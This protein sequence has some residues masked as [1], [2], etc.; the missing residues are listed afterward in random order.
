MKLRNTA[1]GAAVGRPPSRR[2]PGSIRGAAA[3]VGLDGRHA[4]SGPRWWAWRCGSPSAPPRGQSVPGPKALDGDLMGGGL[5]GL[6]RVHDAAHGGA[7]TPDRG[8]VPARG[9]KDAPPGPFAGPEPR[10]CSRP[11]PRPHS[12]R[13]P[14]WLRGRS[15]GER[16]FRGPARVPARWAVTRGRVSTRLAAAPATP[17]LVGKPN[18]SE[19]PVYCVS[20]SDG[21]CA[22]SRLPSGKLA[23]PVR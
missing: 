7:F 5:V 12:R 19:V 9:L 16:T 14:R 8:G 21:R 20:R 4:D 23:E 15:P 18:A 10:P 6:R 1:A 13:S 11:A 3:R 2:P 22:Q 17:V